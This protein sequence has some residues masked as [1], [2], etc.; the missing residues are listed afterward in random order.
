MS[1]IKNLFETDIPL[2]LLS[3]FLPVQYRKVRE[4]RLA[5]N[6]TCFAF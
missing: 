3:Q 2:T 6:A 4:G 5:E 1:L